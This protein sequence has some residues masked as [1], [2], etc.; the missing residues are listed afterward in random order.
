LAEARERE[1]GGAEESKADGC[2]EGGRE[3]G[4]EGGVVAWKDGGR[5]RRG[6]EGGRNQR[7][8]SWGNEI[9]CRCVLSGQT[10]VRL[11]WVVG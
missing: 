1:G 11:I 7:M 9:L 3:G 5:R 10:H 6:R 8:S 2:T 4:R